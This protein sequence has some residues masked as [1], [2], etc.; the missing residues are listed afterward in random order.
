MNAPTAIITP[1]EYAAFVARLFVKRNEGGDGI[2]HAAVG[3]A[4]EGG[5]VLD[6]AKKLWVYSKPLDLGNVIEELGDIE[7]YMQAMRSLLGISRNEVLAANM[8][9]LNKRYPQGYTDAAAQA[10]AD[11]QEAA[12]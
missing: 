4:G 1:A 5:E 11:K 3:I 6:A 9:K 12:A 10:R 2:M 7:F 8:A